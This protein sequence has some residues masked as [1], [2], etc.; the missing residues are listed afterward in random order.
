MTFPAQSSICPAEGDALRPAEPPAQYG[1]V[2]IKEGI[3][4]HAMIT[5]ERTA[6][7]VT[8]R[9]VI[10]EGNYAPLFLYQ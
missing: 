3:R 1:R 6:L 5:S 10:M 2:L 9:M 7:E 4:M 8:G